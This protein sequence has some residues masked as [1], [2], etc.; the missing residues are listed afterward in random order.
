ML[1]NELNDD[2]I[3]VSMKSGR[4]YQARIIRYGG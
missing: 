4:V 3:S 2:V 1:S